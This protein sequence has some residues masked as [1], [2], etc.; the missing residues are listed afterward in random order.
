MLFTIRKVIANRQTY[1][2]ID[3][4]YTDLLLSEYLSP[5]SGEELQFL[6]FLLFFI[7]IIYF[8]VIFGRQELTSLSNIFA[9]YKWRSV[10]INHLG[11]ERQQQTYIH[12]HT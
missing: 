5:F 12:V 3:F 4:E 11:K 1:N 2:S 10:Q 8:T 7:P 6:S 9:R